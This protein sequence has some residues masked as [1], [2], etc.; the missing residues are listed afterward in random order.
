MIATKFGFKIGSDADRHFLRIDS[1]R[2]DEDVHLHLIPTLVAERLHRAEQAQAAATHGEAE[3][4]LADTTDPQI[5]DLCELEQFQEP[6]V[7]P[8]WQRDAHAVRLELHELRGVQSR[9]AHKQR[10]GDGKTARTTLA[11]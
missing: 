2:L 8:G 9:E 11:P 1:R 7:R 3:R 6:A 4:D 5:G 10:D